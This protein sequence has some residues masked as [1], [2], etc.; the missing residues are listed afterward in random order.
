MDIRLLGGFGVA[1]DSHPVPDDAWPQRRAADLVKLLALADG[2]RLARDQ[3]L[4][5]LWP[6]LEAAPAAANLHKAASYARRALGDR[7]AV[8]LRGGQVQLAPGVAVTTDV[9]RLEAGGDDVSAD[10]LLP[11]DRYEQWTL[12]PR[13]R[14]RELRLAGLRRRGLWEEVLRAEPADEEAS[15]ALARAALEAGDRAAAVRRLRS[16]RDELSQLGMRPSE[17]TLALEAEL[18]SGPAVH[19]PLLFDAPIVGRDRELDFART[20]LRQAAGGHGGALLVTGAAGMGKSRFVDALLE[21]GERS[22]FHTLRGGAHAE[23]GTSPYAPFVEAI[24]P[25][26]DERPDLAASLSAGA[27]SALALLVPSAPRVETEEGA[28]VDRHRLLSAVGQLL[29]RAS[30]DR[31]VLLVLDDLHA[32]DD[33]TL[34]LVHYLARAARRAPLMLVVGAREEAISER[35]ARLRSSLIEQHAGVEVPLDRLD[36]TA[37]QAVAERV[38]GRRLPEPTVRAIERSSAGNAFFVEE[39]AAGVDAE[40]EVIVP[41]R[42]HQ[43]LEARVERLSAIAGDLMAPLAVL[44]DGF[45]AGELAALARRDED[46]VA[47]A[48]ESACAAGVL[49]RTRGAY[50]FRHPLVRESLVAR[51]PHGQLAGAHRAAAAMLE[52]QDAPP[53]RIA[54][55]LLHS[56]Q[57]EAAVPLL[58]Q[59]AD[60]AA[61]VA[62][63]ADGAAWVEQALEHA[64]DELR[65]RLLALLAELLDGTGD[66]RAAAAYADAIAASSGGE[67]NDLRLKRARACIISGDLAEAR[68]MLEEVV[69]ATT[70]ER[71]RAALLRSMLSWFEGDMAGS[72]R[73]AEE[74]EP[75]LVQAERHEDLALLDDARAM[76][77]HAEGDWESHARWRLRESAVPSGLAG[78]VFDA[79]L[80]VTE[81]VLYSGEPYAQLAGF[82]KRLRAQA[83][84]AGA[85]RGEAFAATLLGETELLTGNLDAAREHLFEAARI[86]REVG[87]SGGEALARLRLGET[88]LHAGDRDGATAQLEEALELSQGSTLSRHLL[89]LV[90]GVLVQVPAGPEEGLQSVDQAEALLSKQPM[91]AFCPTGYH[92]SAA[93]TCA[94][95]RAARSRPRPPGARGARCR[96]LAAGPV[97]SRACGGAR[98]VVDRRGRRGRGRRRAA[99]GRRGVR[100]GG[101]APLR[102][103]GA[104]RAGPARLTR[105]AHAGTRFVHA[106]FRA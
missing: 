99:P 72:R 35:L 19:A 36:R 3:V 61:S 65:P 93:M 50:R 34:G 27:L 20:L 22:G 66:P 92:V 62:A 68:A 105:A 43:V 83:A 47:G 42:L 87:A 90:H 82:A 7:S 74:A 21:D 88:L 9:E 2:H 104:H 94:A 84:R 102:A 103:P 85:R 100:G 5:A 38:A 26:L 97:A 28:A 55:H 77:A 81:Y 64:G 32:A 96:A 10:D 63:Y 4:E 48:L 46:E 76:L 98:T 1:V 23:E 57:A 106:A 78:R 11:D 79:Y 52:A 40:G 70:A 86:S 24:D 95:A 75:L 44:E 56:G 67:A 31:P 18:T 41:R 59:A 69:P 33:A 60:W 91:C 29:A 14:V 17:E 73:Y 30:R 53:E 16:L 25:L 49:D 6:Q 15:R 58:L 45:T 13:E 80:C 71:G 54:H 37:V 8:V 101:A 39:L 12:A 89:Y 51:V